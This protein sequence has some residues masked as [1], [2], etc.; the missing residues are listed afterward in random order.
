MILRPPRS[1]RTDSLFPYTTLFLSG[2]GG[3]TNVVATS[4][5]QSYSSLVGL[6]PAD[7][8]DIALSARLLKARAG[9][10]LGP[11]K[12]DMIARILGNRAKVLGIDSVA[13][14]LTHLQQ[15]AASGEWNHFVN[16]FTINHTAF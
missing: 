12:R 10:V 7:S 1:T 11:H 14:Y 3:R 6:P 13:D 2:F 9:L 8:D 16:A 15:N 5:A 4:A